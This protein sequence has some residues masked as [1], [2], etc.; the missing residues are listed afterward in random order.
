MASLLSHRPTYTDDQLSTYLALLYNPSH[1]LHT[2]AV[3]K[4][5]LINDPIATLTS[6]QTHHLATIPW[7]DVSLHYSASRWLS[8]DAEAIYD[9]IVV[10]KLGGYCM[11]VNTFYS[12]VLRSFGLKLYLT[13]GRISNAIDAP[14]K[15]DPE[16]FAGW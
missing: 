9:K 6:L 10:K 5:R 14:G 16:G 11:E 12:I 13:G 1:P 3:F 4:E 7:G 8:L 15:R 2:L